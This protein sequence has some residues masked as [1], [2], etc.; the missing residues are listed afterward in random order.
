MI[1]PLRLAT[2]LVLLPFIRAT[3]QAPKE[4]ADTDL[5]VATVAYGADSL[6][7]LQALGQPQARQAERWRYNQLIVY[8]KGGRVEQIHI[9]GPR[10]VRA[11]GLRVGDPTSRISAL[12]GATCYEGSY[13]FC[14]RITDE[15]EPRGIMVEVND[16]HVIRVIVGAVFEP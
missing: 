10:I 9:T 16:D 3:G 11:R 1:R 12:Y 2:T 4:L 5:V 13:T 15:F 14:R 7:V 6:F 8:L